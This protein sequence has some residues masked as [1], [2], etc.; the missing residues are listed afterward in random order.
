M[1]AIHHGMFE[2]WETR[3]YQFRTGAHVR[4]A[5]RREN[6]Q[7]PYKLPSRVLTKRTPPPLNEKRRSINIARM[8][9]GDSRC[10]RLHRCTRTFSQHG[11]IAVRGNRAEH[12]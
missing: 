9:P 8:A 2:H 12:R 5:A 11:L 7:R 1:L 10:F 3:L 4:Y 6:R